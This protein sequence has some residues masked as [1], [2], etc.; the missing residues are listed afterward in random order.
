MC[1]D[2]S[3]CVTSDRGLR[4]DS[5]EE[6]HSANYRK[7]E[8]RRRHSFILHQLMT[9]AKEAN[10]D[11]DEEEEEKEE[12]KNNAVGSLTSPSHELHVLPILPSHPLC[13]PS[14][15][16]QAENDKSCN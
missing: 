5:F 10:R 14:N 1:I 7:D 4:T 13:L 3:V 8:S 15:A 6:I 9:L 2:I 11:D 16:T 12:K